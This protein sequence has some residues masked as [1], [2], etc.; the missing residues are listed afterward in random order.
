HLALSTSTYLRVAGMEAIIMVLQQ[1]AVFEGDASVVRAVLDTS[2]IH[3][4]A[5]DRHPELQSLAIQ[6]LCIILVNNSVAVRQHLFETQIP[7]LLAQLLALPSERV[8]RWS[9][10][11]DMVPQLVQRG[12]TAEQADQL[13]ASG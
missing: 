8:E 11:C 7:A 3:Y 1:P 10:V 2:L 6:A 5:L 4:F 12:L 13:V 9:T